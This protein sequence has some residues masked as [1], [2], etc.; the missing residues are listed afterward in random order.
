MEL[1]PS[2]RFLTLVSTDGGDGPEGD[3]IV[4]GDPVLQM[5]PTEQEGDA[6]MNG[7]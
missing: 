2:D 3:W 6:N 7:P 5:V 4:F 1:G